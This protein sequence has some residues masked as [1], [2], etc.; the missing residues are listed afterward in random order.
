MTGSV[1]SRRAFTKAR[2]DFTNETP[3]SASMSSMWIV[4]WA[5][6]RITGARSL[7]RPCPRVTQITPL[8][9]VISMR[10]S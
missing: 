6:Y 1:P 10:S 7:M 5:L 3:Q 9:P 8:L 4:R 2:P